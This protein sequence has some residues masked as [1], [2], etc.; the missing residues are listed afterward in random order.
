MSITTVYFGAWLL[1][2]LA[3]AGV[4]SFF[5][6]RLWRLHALR[7]EQGLRMLDALT[8]YCE[9]VAA[10]RRAPLFVGES[11]EAAHALD[12]ACAIRVACFPDLAGEMAELLAVHNRLVDFLDR[13]QQLKLRDAEAWLETDHD[14][15][16][17]ALWHQQALAIRAIQDKLRL[18]DGLAP[19]ARAEPRTYVRP[20]LG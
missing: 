17:L 19:A 12:E 11:P 18:S 16:F 1:A 10:Q 4:L 5:A 6:V 13:Q 7:R 8:R 3:A 15:R 9:W 2:A 14:R 20:G